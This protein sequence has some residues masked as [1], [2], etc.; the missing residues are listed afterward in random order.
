MLKLSDHLPPPEDLLD[1]EP[2]QIAGG[3]MGYL[4]AA[5]DAHEQSRSPRSQPAP[6]VFHRGN[7]SRDDGVVEYAGRDWYG[8]VPI[9]LMEAWTWSQSEGLLVPAPHHDADWM[10]LSRRGRKVRNAA[11]L[12]GLR[13]VDLLLRGSLDPRVAQKVWPSFLAGDYDTA[14]FQA[15]REVE[16]AVRAAG[17]FG[18][19][20]VGRPLMRAAF[21]NETGPLTDLEAEGGEREALRMLFDGAIGVFKNP[22]SH[23]EVNYD[24]AVEAAEAIGLASLLLRVVERRSS[25]E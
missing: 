23:R 9:A 25:Q 22:G 2:E 3:L 21:H 10:V 19:G 8:E 18:P 20:T 7:F 1:L 13:R 15:F 17:G 5:A 4:N 24:S 6:K 12:R 11:S 14:V 16:I